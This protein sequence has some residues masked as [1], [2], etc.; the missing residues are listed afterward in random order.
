MTVFVELVVD[1]REKMYYNKE[2]V[3]NLD[4]FIIANSKEVADMVKKA[5]Q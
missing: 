4:G 5:R 3:Y 2:Q 1:F